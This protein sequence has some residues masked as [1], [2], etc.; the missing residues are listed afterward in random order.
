MCSP[1]IATDHERK[2]VSSFTDTSTG[3]AVNCKI[4][5]A[6]ATMNYRKTC[7]IWYSNDAYNFLQAKH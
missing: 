7:K 3:T 1:L 4:N 5:F 2:Y 6:T